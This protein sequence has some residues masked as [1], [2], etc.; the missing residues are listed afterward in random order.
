MHSVQVYVAE[1]GYILS[2]ASVPKHAIITHLAGIPVPDLEAF[3]QVG[4]PNILILWAL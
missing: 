1:T 2:R 4:F 3:A